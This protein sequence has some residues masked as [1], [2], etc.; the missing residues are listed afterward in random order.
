MKSNV[1]SSTANPHEPGISAAIVVYKPDLDALA[2]SISCLK[3]ALQRQHEEFQLRSSLFVIDNSCDPIWFARVSHAVNAVAASSASLEV[4]LIAAPSNGGYG[5]GNNLVLDRMGAEVHVVMNP[6]LFV[7]VDAL[8]IA[9]RCL[10][11]RSDVGLLLAEVRGEDGELHYL[12]KLNPT[13]FDMFLRGFSPGWLRHLFRRRMNAFEMRDRDYTQEIEG[14]SYP[15]GCFMVFRSSVLRAIDGFDERFFLYLEDADIGRRMLRV[16]RVVY[17]PQIR[18]IHSWA[19]GSRRD[20]KL[21]W[22]TIVSAFRYWRK[23][24][25][26]V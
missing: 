21:R 10:R 14:I 24:G 18:V 6:D 25:G 15:T 4:H 16:A 7:D 1:G 3:L 9:V 19:R 23:W 26:V 5:Y 17:F 20:W 8:A 12:C 13:L 22:V 2:R 11:A